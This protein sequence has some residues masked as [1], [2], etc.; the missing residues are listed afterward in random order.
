MRTNKNKKPIVGH[1][2]SVVINDC[3]SECIEEMLA[4]I[5]SFQLRINASKHRKSGK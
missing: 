2:R 3:L 5:S 4:H 1:V